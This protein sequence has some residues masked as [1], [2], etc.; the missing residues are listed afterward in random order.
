MAARLKLARQMRCE[1]CGTVTSRLAVHHIRPV[2]SGRDEEEMRRLC[3]DESN[4][5]VLCYD[6]HSAIHK[7]MRSRTR[8]YHQAAA[9]KRASAALRHIDELDEFTG[10]G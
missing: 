5:Q 8:S 3:F 7:E 6:C 1:G 4:L 2:E 9:A 10:I